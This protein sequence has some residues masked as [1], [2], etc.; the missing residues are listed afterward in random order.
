MDHRTRG[1]AAHDGT[2]G[3]LTGD[4]TIETTVGDETSETATDKTGRTAAGDAEQRLSSPTPT[5][6]HG[7]CGSSSPAP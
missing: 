4:K 3:T 7:E 6:G 5:E 2:S 1:A